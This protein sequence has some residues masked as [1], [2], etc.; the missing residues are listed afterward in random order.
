VLLDG[1]LPPEELAAAV[2]TSV[3]DFL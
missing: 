3:E 2:R 1:A